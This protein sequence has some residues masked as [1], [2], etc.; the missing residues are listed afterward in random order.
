MDDIMTSFVLLIVAHLFL[1]LW[2]A[3]IA[4]GIDLGDPQK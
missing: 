1:A 4:Y 2:S 3:I